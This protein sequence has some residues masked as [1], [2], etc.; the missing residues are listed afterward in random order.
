V[1]RAPLALL[2]DTVLVVHF[3]FVVFVVGGLALIV[4]GGVRGWPIAR[5][6]TFRAAHVAAIGIVV[7]QAWL[8]AAC[9]LTTL[10]R[11]LRAEAAMPTYEGSCIAYWLGRLLYY[12]APAWLFALVYSAFALAVLAAWWRLPPRRPAP[13]DEPA[14]R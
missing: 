5:S 10:E 9:P 12:E 1:E 4:V 3:A 11:W 6:F 2:A 8:G 14:P 7:A 13:T